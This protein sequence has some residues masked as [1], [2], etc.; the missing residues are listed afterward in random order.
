VKYYRIDSVTNA[1]SAV[2][3]LIDA[4]RDEGALPWIHLEAHGLPEGTGF[5]SALGEPCSWQRLREALTPL[6]LATRLN[7]VLVLAACHGLTFARA[8]DV[9]DRAPVLAMIGPGGSVPV[10]EVELSF[11]RFYRTYFE[12]GSMEAALAA[13]AG[14]ENRW[15]YGATNATKFFYDVWR[16]FKK[17]QCQGQ[18]LRKRALELHRTLCKELGS[19]AP[20][21][22]ECK[23][24]L[25]SEKNEREQFDKFR[26]RYFAYDLLEES[27]LRFRVSLETANSRADA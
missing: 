11:P 14:T 8:I 15:R 26:D 21:V 1:E 9:T 2:Q 4:V 24:Q 3:N 20:S 19:D 22:R 12:S 5:C 16:G 7:L 6:N 27:K 10:G 23:K 17:T 13:L 18:V 25:R